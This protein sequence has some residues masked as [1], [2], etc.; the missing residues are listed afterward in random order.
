[1]GDV[2]PEAVA[3]APLTSRATAQLT[4]GVAARQASDYARSMVPTGSYQDGYEGLVVADAV[5]LVEHARQVL[6]AAVVAERADGTSWEEIADVLDT[7]PASAQTRWQ[8]IVS[9]WDAQVELAAVPGRNPHDFPDVLIDLPTLTAA[10]LKA[11]VL[12][13]HEPNDP[14]LGEHPVH[15]RFE[16]MDPWREL[17]RSADTSTPPTRA[18]RRRG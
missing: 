18:R 6:A 15:H 4:L 16:R 14:A 17:P 13:H 10:E 11:W 1:M 8:P 9:E 2:C 3:G 5:R 7:T 12:R